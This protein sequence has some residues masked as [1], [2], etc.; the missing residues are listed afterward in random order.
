M[1]FWESRTNEIFA[2]Q[3]CCTAEFLHRI[4]ICRWIVIWLNPDARLG[5]VFCSTFDGALGDK[6]HSHGDLA[7]GEAKTRPPISNSRRMFCFEKMHFISRRNMQTRVW[8]RVPP[9]ATPMS[10][11][12]TCLLAQHS[13]KHVRKSALLPRRDACCS[14]SKFII[15]KVSPLHWGYRELDLWA[16][17]RN[18]LCAFCRKVRVGT[19]SKIEKSAVGF[20]QEKNS[21]HLFPVSCKKVKSCLINNYQLELR[22]WIFLTRHSK[23][24]ASHFTARL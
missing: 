22:L 14:S 16:V 9:W 6:T 18:S 20:W 8:S 11:S 3:G 19:K 2:S 21:K 4:P 5:S 10:I 23:F 15:K 13:W 17:M 7:A 12:F 24:L 1:H